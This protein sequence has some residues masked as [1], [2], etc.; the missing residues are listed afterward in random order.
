[1]PAAHTLEVLEKDGARAVIAE[2]DSHG[3][4]LLQGLLE[5]SAAEQDEAQAWR[6]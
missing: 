3:N 4:A 1:V 6:G 2:E 5:G